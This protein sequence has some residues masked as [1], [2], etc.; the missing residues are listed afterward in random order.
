MLPPRLV[1]SKQVRTQ[2]L[3]EYKAE[4]GEQHT[5]NGAAFTAL[6]VE[7]PA[8][9]NQYGPD[10]SIISKLIN[11]RSFCFDPFHQAILAVAPCINLRVV[12]YFR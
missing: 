11:C 12:L 2:G 5:A 9:N 6:T 8:A 4:L 3:T 7:F 10:A 1:F